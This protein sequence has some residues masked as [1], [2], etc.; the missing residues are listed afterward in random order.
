MTPAMSARHDLVR[1][2][3]RQTDERRMPR[4][5]TVALS[6]GAAGVLSHQAA[7]HEVTPE[8]LA[9]RVLEIALRDGLLLAIIDG[10]AV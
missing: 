9:S 1:R 8:R 10:E 3:K 2:K 7:L 4:P 5:Y 6:A